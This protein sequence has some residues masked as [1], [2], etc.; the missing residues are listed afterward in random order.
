MKLRV[1]KVTTKKEGKSDT[2]GI[3]GMGVCTVAHLIKRK[4]MGSNLRKE[5]TNIFLTSFIY[6]MNCTD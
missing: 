3:V 2:R 5:T 4:T 1:V 6:I